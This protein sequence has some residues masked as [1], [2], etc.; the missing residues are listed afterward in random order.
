[1]WGVVQPY[2]KPA[3]DV[4]MQ[5]GHLRA[6][7]LVI[8]DAAAAGRRLQFIGLHR[9]C[10]Y[11]LPFR[12]RDAHGEK[13]LFR[14]GTTFDDVIALAEFDRALRLAVMDAI[15][16]IEVAL[17]AAF[18]G[19][20][21]VALGPHWY[22]DAANWDDA[23]RHADFLARVRDELRLDEAP[24]ERHRE[25]VRHYRAEYDQPEYP[26]VWVSFDA[27][28]FGTLSQAFSQL[29]VAHRKVVARTFA[30][31]ESILSSW[32]HALTVLRNICA[33][34]GR[35]THRKFVVR[36][37]VSKALDPEMR[38]Q[39]RLHGM[40]VLIHTLLGPLDTAEEW[41]RTILRITAQFPSVDA[42]AALG[43]PVSSRTFPLPRSSV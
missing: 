7:G 42:V 36:P 13:L 27:V 23:N 21:A 37:K 6:K 38:P 1:V 9:F 19:P 26:P 16:R 28:T 25:A 31:D 8:G 2:C 10:G 4:E 29:K 32:L 43:T 5:L 12:E 35:L 17:R 3:L 24:H 30:V 39:D 14:P 11:A 22:T 33:H 20:L 15:E 40:L 34:H 41:R 18:G